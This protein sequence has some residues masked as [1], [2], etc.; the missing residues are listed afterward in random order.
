MKF[1]VG[2]IVRCIDADTNWIHPGDSNLVNGKIYKVTEYYPK[3]NDG[4]GALRVNGGGTGWIAARFVN[5]K[6]SD[7]QDQLSQIVL[8]QNND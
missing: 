6:M 1:K 3:G 7:F 5:V 4:E 2:D 8:E